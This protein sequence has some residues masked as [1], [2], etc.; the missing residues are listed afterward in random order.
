M[1][2]P[3]LGLL[4]ALLGIF[5]LGGIAGFLIF[6]LGA[7]HG[8][9]WATCDVGW[10]ITQD[11]VNGKWDQAVKL[12]LARI[13]DVR[14][15]YGLY[16]QVSIVYLERAREDVEHRDEWIAKALSY[17]DRAI[18]LGPNDMTNLGGAAAVYENAGGIAKNGCP[19]YEKAWTLVKKHF[20]SFPKISFVRV[21][22]NSLRSHCEPNLTGSFTVSKRRQAPASL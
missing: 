12:E 17:E 21:V 13:H 6:W 9:L 20:L 14:K 8:M 2:R 5:F 3:R 15:D 16:D 18:S 22:A 7:K 10:V 4:G 11:M 1:S 19:Y